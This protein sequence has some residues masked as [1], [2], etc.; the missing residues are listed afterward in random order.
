MFHMLLLNRMLALNMKLYLTTKM[1]KNLMVRHLIQTPQEK[2]IQ[3]LHVMIMK[4]LQRWLNMRLQ[5]NCTLI[6]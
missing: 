4:L 1:L 3:D 5:Y 6:I 2:I